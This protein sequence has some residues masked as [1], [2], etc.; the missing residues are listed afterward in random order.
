MAKTSKI[1]DGE[2]VLTDTGDTQITTMTK[3][4]VIGKRAEAQTEVDHLKLDLTVKEAVVT[5]YD[6]YLKDM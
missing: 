4:E 5:E 3:D 6:N 1:V 2:L